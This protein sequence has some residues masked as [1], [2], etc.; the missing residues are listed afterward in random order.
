VECQLD[1]GRWGLVADPVTG[2]RRV[3]HALI[4]T[5]VCSR[6]VFV[7]LSFTQTLAAVIEGCEA[8]WGFFGGVFR[9][10]IRRQPG[11]GGG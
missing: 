11:P 1:F 4:F 9:V 6:Q 3:A 2:R 8:A 5:A 10:L 7:W